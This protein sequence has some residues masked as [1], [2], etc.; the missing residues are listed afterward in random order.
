MATPLID[1]DGE[2]RRALALTDASARVLDAVLNRDA[3][4]PAGTAPIVRGDELRFR[5][6]DDRLGD[7]VGNLDR[8]TSHPPN[9]G[10]RK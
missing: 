4:A 8:H 2:R 7:R 9:R 6:G 1:V 10:A 3:V 5:A